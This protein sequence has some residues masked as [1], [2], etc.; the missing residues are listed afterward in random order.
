MFRSLGDID[1]KPKKNLGLFI[2]FKNLIEGSANLSK[3]KSAICL[4]LNMYKHAI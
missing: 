2:I 1:E 3:K 4:Q